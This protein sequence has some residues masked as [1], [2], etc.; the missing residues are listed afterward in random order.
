LLSASETRSAAP[1]DSRVE[2]DAD[3]GS[4]VDCWVALEETWTEGDDTSDALV[5]AYV[6]EFDG[7]YEEAIGA[8]GCAGGGMK[9]LVWISDEMLDVHRIDVVGITNHFDRHLCRGLWRG[10]RLCRAF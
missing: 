6:G 4:K 2:A 1:A 5:A 8:M 7:C 3:E 9:V 10:L